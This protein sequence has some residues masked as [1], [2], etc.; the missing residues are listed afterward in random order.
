MTIRK[1]DR[2]EGEL[3][4]LHE[5]SGER[6][7]KSRVQRSPALFLGNSAGPSDSDGEIFAAAQLVRDCKGS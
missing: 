7:R 4:N 5:G 6:A 1:A 2:V 3:E